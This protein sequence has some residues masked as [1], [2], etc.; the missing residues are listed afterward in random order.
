M[1]TTA[2]ETLSRSTSGQH[3][4]DMSFPEQ[5]RSSSRPAQLSVLKM[6]Q[7]YASRCTGCLWSGTDEVD[8]RTASTLS[9]KNFAKSIAVWLLSSALAIFSPIIP[10]SVLQSFFMFPLLSAILVLQCRW[11]FSS[12]N[13]CIF[14]SCCIHASLS[15]SDLVHWYRLSSILEI[16]PRLATFG[17]EL[18]SRRTE[19]MT[20]LHYRA[21]LVEQIRHRLVKFY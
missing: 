16:S 19:L 12:Y 5:H 4:V 10:E 18:M 15:V 1:A 8:R 7:V 21:V 14:L 11:F 2:C 20:Y 13:A 17:I 3:L 9:V 6:N